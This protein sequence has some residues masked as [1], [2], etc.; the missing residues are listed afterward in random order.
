MEKSDAAYNDLKPRQSRFRENSDDNLDSAYQHD[1][2]AQAAKLENVLAGLSKEQL[3]AEVDDFT[4]KHGL[5]EHNEAFRKGALLAQK[6]HEWDDIPEL[7]Q[8]DREA[9]AYEHAH[10]WSHPWPLYYTSE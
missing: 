5:E 10:K 9:I 2:R 7:N 8:E 1:T 4:S 6:P 3:Y